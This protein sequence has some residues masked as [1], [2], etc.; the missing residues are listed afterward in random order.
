MQR[1]KTVAVLGGSG[2]VGR[3]VVQ[4]LAKEG[5]NIRVIVRYPHEALFLKTQGEVG[6]I[7]LIPGSILDEKS[8][9]RA[10]EGAD[11][12]INLVGILFEK[13]FQRFKKIHHEGPEKIAKIAVEKGVQSLIHLSA[14]GANLESASQY[15]QTKA[16][17]EIAL[18]KT[19]P[20]AIIF[21]PSV[22]FGAEDQFLNRFAK[23]A[24]SSPFLPLIGG[25]K[26]RLQPVY[27]QDVAKA[28]VKSLTLPE[29][30]GKIFELGG[31][32]VY[33]FKE[34]IQLI[35]KTIHRRRLLISIPV[36]FARWLGFILQFHPTPPLTKDQ[37]AL[38]KNDNVVGE[39]SLKF[40]DLDLFP[41]ALEDHLPFLLKR[42]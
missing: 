18:Q 30:K 32:K 6:Q 9:V 33:T 40:K 23:M 41:S 12:V 4:E 31:P 16:R 22:I 29:A 3:Y 34:I 13:G 39:K 5:F 42:F 37:V 28:V 19:F 8:L 17:G 10:F 14:L 36:I 21:R 7:T 2:F 26:T 1:E 15:A 20:Q 11:A 27:V 35:L 24:Q 38:L 25:G